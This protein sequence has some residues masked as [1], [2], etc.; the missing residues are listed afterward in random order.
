[1]IVSW[2][3]RHLTDRGMRLLSF[4]VGIFAVALG[5]AFVGWALWLVWQLARGDID[6]WALAT[7]IVLA[8]FSRGGDRR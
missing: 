5:G 6:D 1:M 7:L 3:Q 4:A 2:L 8:L